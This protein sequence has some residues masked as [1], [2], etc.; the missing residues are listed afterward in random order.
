VVYLRTENIGSADMIPSNE[1]AATNS[2]NTWNFGRL[3]YSVVIGFGY[4]PRIS[5]GAVAEL[6]VS[7]FL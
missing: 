4:V 7:P 5:V 3:A 1:S 2:R 6:G